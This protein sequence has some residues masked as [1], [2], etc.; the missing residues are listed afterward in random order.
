MPSSRRTTAAM[1]VLAYRSQL[2]REWNEQLRMIAAETAC[3]AGL[4]GHAPLAPAQVLTS[5]LQAPLESNHVLDRED[6]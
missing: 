1:N 6:E 3:S 5:R 4:R 2:R